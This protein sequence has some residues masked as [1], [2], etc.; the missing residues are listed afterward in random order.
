MTPEERER[1]MAEYL[2]VITDSR[3]GGIQFEECFCKKAAWRIKD[4][5]KPWTAWGALSR[6]RQHFKKI[7][8]RYR[9]KEQGGS[10]K[11]SRDETVQDRGAASEGPCKW[12]VGEAAGEKA[13]QGGRRGKGAA[14]SDGKKIDRWAVARHGF[15][16]KSLGLDFWQKYPSGERF[17]VV[18]EADAMHYWA[19]KDSAEERR[20]AKIRR[21]ELD[22]EFEPPAAAPNVAAAAAPAWI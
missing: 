20:E 7:L 21:D 17:W 10:E 4:G 3:F 8:D 15:E 9:G 16:D 12:R 13:K 22:F 2:E 18:R 11:R 6:H 14:R 1:T 5:E 19:K